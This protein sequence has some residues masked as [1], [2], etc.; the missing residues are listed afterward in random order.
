MGENDQLVVNR[1]DRLGRD[2]LDVIAT[3]RNL[4]DRDI[5]QVVLGLGTLDN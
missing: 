2:I 4:T 3:L 5:T 1:F